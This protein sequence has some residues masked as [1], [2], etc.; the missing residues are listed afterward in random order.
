VTLTRD[1]YKLL[2]AVHYS[3]AKVFIDQTP[4]H[5]LQALANERNGAGN[6]EERHAVGTLCHAMSLEGKDL[7]GT[8]AIKPKGMSFA[9]TKGKAW[10]DAQTLPILKEEDAN[11]V[12]KMAD[13]IAK[14][15]VAS[16]IIR[17][18]PLREWALVG[19][20]GGLNCKAL[21]DAVG[22]DEAGVRGFVE[23]KTTSDASPRAF[24]R[25]I[26]ALHYDM[27]CSFY[28]TLLA[29]SEGLEVA[30]WMAW[31]AVENAP[32]WAVACYQPSESMMASGNLKVAEFFE[33]VNECMR[34]GNWP[35]YSEEIIELDPPGYRQRELEADALDEWFVSQGG[36]LVSD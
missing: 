14:H 35:A 16:R 27:Q 10:R 25:Q 32:P 24:A 28:S 15:P 30:P 9:T 12:P 22:N 34:T 5:Y 13:A 21:L 33:G 26:Y 3:T 8:F 1:K 11:R 2:D 29:L 23:I 31:I 20:M 17:S 7:L 36:V 6:D 18:C 19:Q 4:A